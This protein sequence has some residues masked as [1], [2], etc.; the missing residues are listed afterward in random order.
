MSEMLLN[1]IMGY[2]LVIVYTIIFKCCIMHC[3]YSVNNYDYKQIITH[4]KY[5]IMHYYHSYN[6]KCSGYL[7]T[8]NF[9]VKMYARGTPLKTRKCPQGF[10]LK[11]N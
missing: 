7:F 9:F 5:V 4:C 3:D 6:R 1:I 8:F 10:I 2:N 11:L